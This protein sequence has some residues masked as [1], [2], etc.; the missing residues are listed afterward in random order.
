[1]KFKAILSKTQ[2]DQ[3]KSKPLSPQVVQ[4]VIDIYATPDDYAMILNK[5]FNKVFEVTIKDEK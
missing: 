5:Y 3:V 2:T 4:L 1:M